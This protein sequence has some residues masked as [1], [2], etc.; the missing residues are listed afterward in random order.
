VKPQSI[1]DTLQLFEAMLVAQ[2]PAKRTREIWGQTLTALVRFTLPGLG[3]PVPQGRKL[4]HSE[5]NAAQV[6][7]QALPM[8]RLAELPSLQ[9]QVFDQLRTA[10]AS[11][12]TYRSRLKAFLLW[13]QAQSWYPT[14]VEKVSQNLSP[15]KY[16]GYGNTRHKTLTTR[17]RLPSYSL[18]S[19]E[20]SVLLQAE[21]DAFSRFFTAEYAPGR[22][23]DALKPRTMSCRLE[24]LQMILGWWH[25]YQNVPLESLHLGLLVPHVVLRQSDNRHQALQAAEQAAEALDIWLCQ[26]LEFLEQQ[27]QYQSKASLMQALMPVHALVRF[28]YCRETADTKYADIPAMRVVRGHLNR[29]EKQSQQDQPVADQTLKWLDLPQVWQRVV[30]PLRYECASRQFDGQQRPLTAI[31]QSFHLF[32]VWGLLTFRPPRRQQE[33]RDLK[34]SLS[35]PVK[36]PEGLADGQFIQPLPLDRHQDKYAGYLYKDL[37]GVWYEDKTPESYK[38]GKTYGYQKIAV[39]NLPFPDG[40]CFYDYL[41]AFLYGYYRDP[42]GHWWSGG[43]VAETPRWKGQW[44]SLRMTLN[45]VSNHVFVRPNTGQPH[46]T[47]TVYSMIRSSAHRFTG[48]LVT[49]HLLRDI[50]ATWFLD[51]GY[52]EDRINSLAY[53]MGHSVEVLRRIYD[54]RRPQQKM[55]PIQE[56]VMD[57]LAKHIG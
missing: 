8:S 38:T 3:Q 39:P 18:K 44:Y 32:L 29:L 12:Y 25:H 37:D 26:Y 47:G 17:R 51:E 19:A 56:V 36:R 28:Q 48:Q 22:K 27:R 14:T 31:A 10:A 9:E 46:Q 16:Y 57:L 54:K 43:A 15:H 20:I 5:R 23:Q 13:A 42:D 50:Y 34:V 24:S 30:T 2:Q 4:T 55:R 7:L 21:L 52:T 53:A 45:P 11:R 41:E 40:K 6:C 33:F 35:C 49:P 1:W